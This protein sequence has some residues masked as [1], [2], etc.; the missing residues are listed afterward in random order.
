MF[1]LRSDKCI[2]LAEGVESGIMEAVD[3]NKSCKCKIG[4]EQAIT[5]NHVKVRMLDMHWFY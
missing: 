4:S 3:S 1:T 5:S 2:I